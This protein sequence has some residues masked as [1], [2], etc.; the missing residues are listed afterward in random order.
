MQIDETNYYQTGDVLYFPVLDGKPKGTKKKAGN[1]IHQG[2]DNQH[3][4]EGSFQLLEKDNK[5]FIEVKK[6]SV[7]K[8]VEHGD[9]IIPKGIYVKRI[10]QEKD[11]FTEEVRDLID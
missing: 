3:T 6:K 2:R 4:I 11:H 9:V 7:L 5:L 10:I 8:H 1:L